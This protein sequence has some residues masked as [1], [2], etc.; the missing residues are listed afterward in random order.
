MQNFDLTPTDQIDLKVDDGSAEVSF[1]WTEDSP[2]EQG[3]L[4]TMFCTDADKEQTSMT[5]TQQELFQ[6]IMAGCRFLRAEFPK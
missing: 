6:L 2:V 1:Y 4:V 5:L 3:D